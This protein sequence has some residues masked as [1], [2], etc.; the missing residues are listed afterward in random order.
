MLLGDPDIEKSIGIG[1]LK[2]IEP[3]SVGHRGRDADDFRI[4]FC[5]LHHCAAKKFRVRRNGFCFLRRDACHF[6]EGCYAV[7]GLQVVLGRLIA[8]P[9]SRYRMD[10]DRAGQVLDILEYVY[11]LYDVMP[12]DRPEV[13]KSQGLE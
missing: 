4:L 9:F 6:I 12:V 11:E 1:F 8:L 5:K 3:C 13:S 10:K 7:E 2:L